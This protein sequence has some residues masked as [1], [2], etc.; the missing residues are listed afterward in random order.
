MS[1]P[2]MTSYLFPKLTRKGQGQNEH[3]GEA[4]TGKTPCSLEFGSGIIGAILRLEATPSLWVCRAHQSPSRYP[5][6]VTLLGTLVSWV[7]VRLQSL[8]LSHKY[9]KFLLPITLRQT[10]DTS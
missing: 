10:H 6:P 3:L 1:F 9:T 4:S 7:T 8:F 2:N 5:T